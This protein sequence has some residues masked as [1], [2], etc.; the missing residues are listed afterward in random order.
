MTSN[1]D[2]I[3]NKR[4]RTD[5]WS[6]YIVTAFG[7]LVLLTLVILVTHLITQ[8]LPLALIPSIELEHR[9]PLPENSQVVAS[10]DVLGAQPMAIYDQQCKLSLY[11]LKALNLNKIHEYIRP[12]EHKLTIIS[13][14]GEHTLVDV[15]P[16]GQVR[17]L[18][19]RA[20]TY[21][22]D[23][24][25]NTDESSASL[26]FSLPRDVWSQQLN[27]QF[28]LSKNWAVA[29][30]ITN[31]GTFLRWVNRH[32]PTRFID[33]SFP[34]N[35]DVTVLAGSQMM[36]VVRDGEVYLS[37]LLNDGVESELITAFT[38]PDTSISIHSLEKDRTFFLYREGEG[39]SR[40]VLNRNKA[41]LTFSK[42]YN[43]KLQKQERLV[44]VKEHASVN[45]VAFLTNKKRLLLLNRI[46]G[47]VVNTF[48][49]APPIQRISWF[50]NRL[51]GFDDDNLYVWQ[52]KY[53]SGVTTWS[54]L[55]KP[56]HYE[57]YAEEGAVWQTTHASDYQEAKFSITPLIIGSM[58]A[59]LLALFI[60]IP[61]AIGAAVYSGFF[62]NHRL[63]HIIKPAIEMLE[64][65]PSVLIGFIAAI[66]LAPKAE[67]FLF[68]FAFFLIIVPIVLIATA[69]IQRNLAEK[70]PSKLRQGSE[71]WFAILGIVILGYISV[72]WAP[73]WLFSIVG[74]DGYYYLVS[75]TQG[76]IGKTT[77][78]VAIALGVAISPS[79]Y[80]LAE[81]A[82]N[83]VP[84]DLKFASFALG[85]TRV[86]TLFHVVLRVA[87]PGILAAIMLG[88]GRAFG[89]TMIV[90]MVTGNT[91]I[92]S[93]GL[94][95]G[96]RALTANLAIELPEADVS[97]A[98][99][100]ILFLTAGVLFIFTFTVN[101]IAELIRQYLRR[102][103]YY[104]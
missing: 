46:T 78:V 40:W 33:K 103:T 83:G 39:V 50:G 104:D 14:M 16:K 26:S 34:V 99:Y 38:N 77:I 96:L 101:T 6:R 21:N 60:A 23:V 69:T 85:A 76:P 84:N 87:M 32:T 19:V 3:N 66:W 27:W 51:Y 22:A 91:P 75:E 29:K 64:A 37:H 20:L 79:I 65:I 42:T 44:D 25:T 49:L 86:Q 52:A 97:S 102:R 15:S 4:Q 67:Q 2:S 5:K 55:F 10:G 59:S 35:D 28:T 7:G 9:F 58:K 72:T 80:T 62:A 12:C 17:M 68:S 82:I 70:L 43:V 61:L 13:L 100:Q 47:E 54:S 71:L 45:I 31:E 30:V 88:F 98:H 73:S 89:E 93:W 1:S 8:A 81:D 36:V 11:G 92:A 48:A 74:F 53:L 56:Q 90:L 95:E 18:P 94:I 41:H 57:G 63:R 24:N